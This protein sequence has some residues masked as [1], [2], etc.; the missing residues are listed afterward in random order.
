MKHHLTLRSRML[1]SGS[2][3]QRGI[4]LIT[5]LILL[6]VIT[7]VALLAVQGSISGEQVSRN[8]R[9]NAVA[10]QA[11]ETALRL[12][13]DDILAVTSTFVIN[14]LPN[15]GTPTIPSLWAST[16]TWSDP[17]MANTVTTAD[18]NSSNAAA[19]TLTDDVLPQC[20]IEEYPILTAQGGIPRQ[21]YLIT[22]RGFSADYRVN[23]T[24]QVV[25]G[26]VVWLQS[27]LRR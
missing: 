23:G 17:L 5:A 19:R 25:S 15:T 16:A 4:V 7:L 11:A 2:R 3:V 18:A 13:E 10:N 22:A 20:V 24:G 26:S 27:I 12:C 6:V 1:R 21:S 8:L 14:R 9:I